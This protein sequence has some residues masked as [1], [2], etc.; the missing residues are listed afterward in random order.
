[1]IRLEP[2][3]FFKLRFTNRYTTAVLLGGEANGGNKMGNGIAQTIEMFM[4]ANRVQAS[5][6]LREVRNCMFDA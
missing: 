3:N 5:E 6:V 4:R 1:M 2:M